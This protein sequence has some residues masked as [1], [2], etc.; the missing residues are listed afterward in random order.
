MSYREV[1][2]SSVAAAALPLVLVMLSAAPAAG[3]DPLPPPASVAAVQ[4]GSEVEVSWDA[5]AG[6]TTYTASAD[7]G[8]ACTST[9]TSCRIAGLTPRA[10]YTFTVTAG[11]ATRTSAASSPSPSLF[12]RARLAAPR[13]DDAK[14]LVGRSR[15]GRPIWAQRQGDPLAPV[16]LLTVG[17]MHGSEPAGLRVTRRVR[18]MDVPDDA[19]YQVWTIR[20]MNPDG[21][22]RSNRYN[23]RGVDLNRNFP[24]TWRRQIRTGV[25][26]ASEP[27]TQAMMDF[28]RRLRPT[29]VVTLHQPWNTALSVCDP[30]SAYWVRLAAQLAGV[31]D[32]G[33]ARDCGNWLPGTM[34]RWTTRTVGAWFVTLELP[35]SYKVAPYIPR[36]SQAVI[37][38]A[39]RMAAADSAAPV[40]ETAVRAR[41]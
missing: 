36:A 19:P 31:R 17:Q 15:K 37:A 25:Q 26:A 11:D 22:V 1:V 3:N 39:E 38:L 6:A 18:A 30:Q 13:F 32:P 24:G 23:S 29:G 8:Q 35:A 21:A 14:V 7:T 2:T 27:E 41:R 40:G 16:I 12:L 10:A 4:R 33:P 34:N 28:L 9:S 20:T 5:V